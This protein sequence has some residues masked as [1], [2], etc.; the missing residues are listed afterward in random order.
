[1]VCVGG[2]Y[3]TTTSKKYYGCHGDIQDLDIR[4]QLIF[5]VKLVYNMSIFGEKKFSL[6]LTLGYPMILHYEKKFFSGCYGDDQD[7]EIRTQLVETI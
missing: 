6:G 1:M 5:L 2:T 7:Q 4:T 3:N